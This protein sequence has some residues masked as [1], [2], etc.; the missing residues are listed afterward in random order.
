MQ[1]VLLDFS[2]FE[3]MAQVLSFLGEALDFPPY[4]GRNLD[5]LYDCLTDLPEGEITLLHPET[6]WE[7]LGD[8]G[9]A[10]LDTLRDAA[11]DNP[12][13]RLVFPEADG[14]EETPDE[15]YFA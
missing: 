8:Y 10:C 7:N 13:L 5:A 3:T 12:N 11:R 14:G 6:L 1:L 4:Y 2:V 15:T 9:S